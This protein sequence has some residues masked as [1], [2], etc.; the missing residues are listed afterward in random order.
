MNLILVKSFIVILG[1]L[2]DSMGLFSSGSFT[3]RPKLRELGNL[4]LLKEF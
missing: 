4:D 2:V 3:Y 1:D